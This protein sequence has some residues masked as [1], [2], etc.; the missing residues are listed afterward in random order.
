MKLI[1]DP[2]GVT[3]RVRR[4]VPRAVVHQP[5]RHELRSGI[6]GIVVVVEEIAEGKSSPGDGVAGHGTVTR[7]LI[8]VALHVLHRIAE[9][10]VM[11]KIK[12]CDVRFGSG[13][14][15]ARQFAVGGI[16]E[17]IHVAETPP[18]CDFGIKDKLCV[19]AEAKSE[20]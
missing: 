16:G 17:S 19:L 11:R 3:A 10:E 9:T 6:V 14:C 8:L 1:D 2:P 12:A 20:E 13:G 15:N 18:P 5:P 4:I 7:Q